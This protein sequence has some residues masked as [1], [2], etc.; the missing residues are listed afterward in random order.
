MHPPEVI[1]E[2]YEQWRAA[3]PEVS[4]RRRKGNGTWFFVMDLGQ[5]LKAAPA[6]TRDEQKAEKDLPLFRER[7]A[8]QEPSWPPPP[9][10]SFA[11][12]ASHWLRLEGN[13]VTER[14]KRDV[15]RTYQDE[16]FLLGPMQL[17]DIRS[18]DIQGLLSGLAMRKTLG[19]FNRAMKAL[20]LLFMWAHC[21]RFLWKVPAIYIPDPT[22]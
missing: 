14:F 20:I 13:R 19:S 7:A 11:E 6:R 8:L 2:A 15:L 5:G 10:I 1:S 9:A 18:E 17:D 12:L 16:L 22:Q 4:L 3:L 21:H